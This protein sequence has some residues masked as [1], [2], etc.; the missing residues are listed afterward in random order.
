MIGL[1][2][3]WLKPNVFFPLNEAAPPDYSHAA[4]ATKQGGDVALIFTSIFKLNSKQD[5]KFCSF[6]ALVLKP[7]PPAS[8][9][10]VHGKGLK[11]VLET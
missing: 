1:Y 5:N 11:I 8:N 10:L 9:C 4:R 6:E 7:S 2:E 3:M